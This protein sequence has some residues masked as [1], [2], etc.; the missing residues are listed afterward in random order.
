MET[1]WKYVEKN[2]HNFDNRLVDML[3]VVSPIALPKPTLVPLPEAIAKIIIGQMLSSKAANSIYER[4]V[5]F[6]D[7]YG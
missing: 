3:K 4:I 1:N 6:K 7:K 2:L 5:S